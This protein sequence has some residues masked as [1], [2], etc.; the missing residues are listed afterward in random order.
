[1]CKIAVQ[2]VLLLYLTFFFSFLLRNSHRSSL[3][4]DPQIIGQAL[5]FKFIV[6]VALYHI[7]SPIF[8]FALLLTLFFALLHTILIVPDSLC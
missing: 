7:C 2:P 6:L 5:L 4:K 8:L 1:M 3:F